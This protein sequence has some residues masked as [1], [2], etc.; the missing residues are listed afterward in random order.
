MN[1]NYIVFL[2]NAW[3][4]VYAGGRYPRHIWLRD[5]ERCRSGQRLKNFVTDFEVCENVT[6]DVTPTSDGLAKPNL[7]HVLDI[8]ERRKPDIV[9]ACGKVAGDF[10]KR[11]WGGPLIVTPHPAHRTV[12]NELFE[13]VDD[14]LNKYFH[15]RI[16]LK[17]T[18]EGVKVVKI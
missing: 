15:G 17:Q 2:Q 1:V 12:T 7:F 6:P 3:S 14:Y 10:L 5:L 16:E 9:V 11:N 13:S 8:I 4:P 18:R